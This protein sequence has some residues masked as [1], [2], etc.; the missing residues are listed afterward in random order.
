[1]PPARWPRRGSCSARTAWDEPRGAG[2][3]VRRP[4]GPRPGQR[5]RGRGRHGGGLRDGPEPEGA[6]DG[7]DRLRR[8]LHGLGQ[9]PRP[10]GETSAGATCRRDR[11]GQGRGEHPG[12]RHALLPHRAGEGVACCPGRKRRPS[13]GVDSPSWPAS[14]RSATVC[15]R[16]GHPPRL[17]VGQDAPSAG[18]PGGEDRLP[19]RAEWVVRRR[20]DDS[21][22]RRWGPPGGRRRDDGSPSR[23]WG[24]PRGRRRDDGRPSRRWGP[25]GGR[26]WDDGRPSRRW[27]PPGGRRWDDGRPSRRWVHLPDRRSETDASPAGVRRAGQPPLRSLRALA[28]PRPP[29]RE[30]TSRRRPHRRGR[31]PSTAARPPCWA[32]RGS[33]RLGASLGGAVSD[34]RT[35][36]QLPDPYRQ[37]ALP[38]GVPMPCHNV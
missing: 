21:P 6:P 31:P 32:T 7:R 1:M 28:L 23:R 26:R 24:P 36:R 11:L 14:A 17:G 37:M 25:P 33:H 19:E 34:P 10:E 9:R 29:R 3:E 8:R 15:R 16:S 4:P 13:L 2:R 30:G 22:S 5:S 35:R 12:D 20:E 18:G 38:N 27:G